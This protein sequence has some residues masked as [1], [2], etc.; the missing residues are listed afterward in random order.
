MAAAPA[1]NDA[2]CYDAFDASA[3]QPKSSERG[4]LSSQAPTRAPTAEPMVLHSAGSDGELQRDGGDEDCEPDLAARFAD[5]PVLFA[6]EC[7]GAHVGKPPAKANRKLPSVARLRRDLEVA[8]TCRPTTHSIFETVQMRP[9]ETQAADEG[10]VRVIWAGA[11]ALGLR[12]RSAKPQPV[13]PR[14]PAAPPKRKPFVSG[15]RAA[16][17]S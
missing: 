9:T 12:R 5:D 3:K 16:L 10:W 4:P 13:A 1:S 6:A 11:V 14:P 8:K 2:S 15:P 7:S 17:F